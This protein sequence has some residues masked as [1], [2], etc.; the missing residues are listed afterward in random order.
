MKE[1]VDKV[2]LNQSKVG[3]NTVKP[4]SKFLLNIFIEKNL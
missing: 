1:I 2:D 3:I 4:M